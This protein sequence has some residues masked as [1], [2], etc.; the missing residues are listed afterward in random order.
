MKKIIFLVLLVSF[1]F[2]KDVFDVA[3][4]KDQNSFNFENIKYEQGFQKTKAPIIIHNDSNNYWMRITLH[5][6]LLTKEVYFLNIAS[7]FGANPIIVDPSY[8]KHLLDRSMRIDQTTPKV[9]YFKI[10]NLQNLVYIAINITP[11]ESFLQ[12]K[13]VKTKLYGVA[14]GITFTAFLYYLLFFIYN[15]KKSFLYYSLTQFFA[16]LLLIFSTDSSYLSYDFVSLR[17]ISLGFVVFSILF[18]KEFLE[19]KKYLPKINIVLTLMIYINIFDTFFPLRNIF[20]VSILMI[21]YPIAAILVYRKTRQKPI[22]FYLTAWSLLVFTITLITVEMY[23]HSFFNYSLDFFDLLHIVIPLESIILAFALSYTM[24]LNED[25]KNEKEKLLIYQSKLASMGEM[26][27]NIAHQWR[28]PITHLSYII[29]NINKAYEHNKLTTEYLDKKITEATQ[30][31]EYMSHT[32]DLFKE[33]YI[34]KT[35]YTDV[36]IKEEINKAIQILES[37]LQEAKVELK[38]SGEDFVVKGYTGELSQVILNLVSNGIEA[39][40]SKAIEK[41][42]IKINFNQGTITIE[43]NALGID[44]RTKEQIFLPYFTTKKEGSGIGLYISKTI[45]EKHFAGSLTHKNTN[46]GS[47]FIIRLKVILNEKRRNF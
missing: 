6:E 21:V 9:L 10:V 32:I 18:T 42:F 25:E 1:C 38:I 23:I 35:L 45:I 14:Y 24:K 39:L 40:V 30:Q 41:P 5:K 26:I 46:K 4:I 31:I 22:L 7:I 12:T 28:Q 44:A 3:I 19:T 37:V 15:R 2:A 29:M 8:K 17:F 27:N 43:D 20:P 33:F 34:P 13:Y 11:K 36:S 47:L 16:L